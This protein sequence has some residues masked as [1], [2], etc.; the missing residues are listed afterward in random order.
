MRQRGVRPGVTSA[1]TR[2]MA[3]CLATLL[4]GC[5]HTLS[6]TAGYA[7]SG[8]VTALLPPP[9]P[10]TRAAPSI[11]RASVA[12]P[13]AEGGRLVIRLL[14]AQE[15]RPIPY[16]VVTVA[17]RRALP[18]RDSGVFVADSLGVGRHG[19]RAIS[20]G[21]TELRDSVTVQA[22]ATDTLTVR[23]GYWCGYSPGD[24]GGAGGRRSG[25]V[26]PFW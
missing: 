26:R 11:M 22:H 21:Y 13:T 18:V 7:S 9:C 23:L 1:A 6:A 2:V 4:V 25:D 15:S 24:R 16:A 10:A 12:A 17:T 19:F 14:S 20:I 3:V 8:V 5:R